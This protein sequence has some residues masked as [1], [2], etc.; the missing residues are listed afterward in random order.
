[1]TRKPRLALAALV[2]AC[3]SQDDARGSER[4]AAA[5]ALPPASDSSYFHGMITTR[6]GPAEVSTPPL[7][8]ATSG[9]ILIEMHR[10]KPRGSAAGADGVKAWLSWDSRTRI[11]FA[12][13]RAATGRDLAVGQVISAGT[14]DP[15]ELS[16]PAQ[17]GTAWIRIDSLP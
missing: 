8:T 6:S 10:T 4:G 3:A 5:A 14:G 7:D 2:L 9:R 13:G 16:N 11:T 12:D 1:M 15:V 17:A